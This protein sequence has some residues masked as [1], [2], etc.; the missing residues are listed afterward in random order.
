MYTCYIWKRKVVCDRSMLSKCFPRRIIGEIHNKFWKDTVQS[1]IKFNTILKYKN[2]EQIC[3]MPLWHN[4]K[5]NFDYRKDW[6][7]KGYHIL[8]DLLNEE[9]KLITKAEM[10][11]RNLKI[12]LLDYM[13]LDKTVKRFFDTNRKYENR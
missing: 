1:V 5:L 2:L 11:E 9:G 6:E 10:N 3:D 4:S 8:N 13:K 7:N 12:H